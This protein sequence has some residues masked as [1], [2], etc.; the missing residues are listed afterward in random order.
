[1]DKEALGQVFS[2][3]FGFPSQFSFHRLLH[4][5]HHLS[6]GAGTIGQTVAD[7]PSGPSLTPPQETKKKGAVDVNY[8]YICSL[9]ISA[10]LTFHLN[11]S[12]FGDKPCGQTMHPHW[13]QY[14][15]IS[16][17]IKQFR[18]RLN[19]WMQRHSF[20]IHGIYNPTVSDTALS[21]GAQKPLF[22]I[23]LMMGYRFLVSERRR[24]GNRGI[25]TSQN[26]LKDERNNVQK[27]E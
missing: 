15:I 11:L 2:E 7:V 1:V 6:S 24:Q 19:V 8:Y 18:W 10:F 17:S 22:I 4:I 23:S 9:N 20:H 5:H 14:Q 13:P 12:S 26:F 16:E 21:S 27:M 3:Y 25:L